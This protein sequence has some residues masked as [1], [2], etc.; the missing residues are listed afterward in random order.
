MPSEA[1]KKRQAKKKE[2]AKQRQRKGKAEETDVKN[3]ES[4]GTQ[5]GSNGVNGAASSLAALDINTGRSVT[6]V[7]ASHPRSRD[8]KIYNFS[9]TFHG[10]ELLADTKIELNCGRRYG[11]VGLNG[12][13]KSTFLTALGL[14]EVPIPDHIDI[15][16][17]T[18][19][20]SASDKTALQCVMDADAERNRLEKESEEIG[21]LESEADRLMEIFERLD[22]LDADKAEMTAASILHGLGFTPEMQLTACKHF[23][24]GWRMRI[25]LAKALYIKPHLLILDEPTNHLDLDACVWLEEELK[26]YKRILVLVSHSQ[27]FLNGVCSNIIHLH[28]RKLQYYGGNYDTY[29]R[30][31]FELEENQM[32]R[33]NWEQAQIAHMKDYIARFGHGSAKLARQAQSK[34][35]TLSKMVAGGLADRVVADK[36]LSFYFPDC[37]KVPPPVLMVQNV[38]FKYGDDLPFIYKNL[39]FGIDLDSRVALVGPNGAGKSTLI[40]LLLSELSPSDGLVR[41]HPHLRIGRFH[42]HLQEALDLELS[43]L[44]Y[45]MKCF[46]EIKE[47]EDMRKV[48]GRYGLTGKQQVCPMRNLSDGQRSRVIFAWISSQTP[49][50]LL[51]DEPTNH[52]D[53]ETIDA[54]ADAINNFEG[55]MV[56][57]SHDFRLIGQVAKEIWVC[58]KQKV[59]K[60]KG[61]ILGYKDNLR[62]KVLKAKAKAK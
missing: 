26:D 42:Q 23:S 15:F 27:D 49:H 10:V 62:A 17:L 22:E 1:A 3:G 18:R 47:K 40:K 8:I 60:W 46:P 48:I 35:K 38:S 16:H 55:G 28:N 31:R 29:V 54:L 33:Y 25:A 2:A 53:I 34:E 52:L 51:L 9:V 12:S 4:N 50:L 14:R 7:L 11:L 58:Q 59:T 20:I 41:K 6:G 39:E 32:K 13:G 43:A 45:M 44:D 36:T 56:L 5:N 21:H 61:D 57:V 19:E 30:T 37:G 24:G